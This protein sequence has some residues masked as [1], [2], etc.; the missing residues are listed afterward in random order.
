LK[1][2]IFSAFLLLSFLASAFIFYTQQPITTETTFEPEAPVKTE[3][4][5]A[6]YLLEPPK[7]RVEQYTEPYCVIVPYTKQE[8]TYENI[9]HTEEG[10]C[11]SSGWNQSWTNSECTIRNTDTVG[12]NFIIYTGFEITPNYRLPKGKWFKNK[13]IGITESAY[14]PAGSSKTV[15]FSQQL[16]LNWDEKFAGCY[17][18]AI[19]VQK[20][21]NCTEVS[22][23]RK[24]CTEVVKYRV[25]E[26]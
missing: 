21:E 4:T 3:Q 12:S 11:Y 22:G 5:Q 23:L 2:W 20:R 14:I 15:R 24:E 9:L 17:C 8:C 13:Q 25:V 19:S 10:E 1:V 16:K 18:Y 6:D 7:G 26:S